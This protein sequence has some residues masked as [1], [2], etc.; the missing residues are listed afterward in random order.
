MGDGH[1]TSSEELMRLVQ[2]GS[3]YGLSQLMRRYANPL[4]TFLHRMTGDYHLSEELFQETFLA[5]WV[6]RSRYQF[7]RSFQYWLFGIAS[8]QCKSRLR[9]LGRRRKSLEQFRTLPT[10]A[11]TESP[12]ES[13]V[14]TETANLVEQAVLQLPDQQREVVV[15]RVWND[16][17]YKSIGSILNRT[18]GTVRS[19]MHH[20]LNSMRTFLEPRLRDLDQNLET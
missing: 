3:R 13:A 2:A 10:S 20:A 5:V 19:H 17:S 15:L 9:E 12:L 8:K 7:P 6:S 1:T 4:L 14:A 18:E 11:A 16:L